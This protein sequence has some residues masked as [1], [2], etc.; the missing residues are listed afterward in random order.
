M[1]GQSFDEYRD[2]CLAHGG[3]EASIE[4]WCELWAVLQPRADHGWRVEIALDESPVWMFGLAGES[5]MTARADRDWIEVFAYRQ[6]DV[7][8][9]TSMVDFQSWLPQA[10]R[11]H[12]GFSPTYMELWEGL[13][14]SGGHDAMLRDHDE[15]LQRQQQALGTEM[16]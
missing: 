8:P 3:G 4:M 14:E 13:N 16:H 5:H 6:D 9:F 15:Q 7:E 1:T 12:S 2:A 10:E 11:A